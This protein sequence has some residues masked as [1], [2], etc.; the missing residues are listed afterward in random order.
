MQ[1]Q[2]RDLQQEQNRDRVL[3][4]LATPLI[5]LA[6]VIWG[7]S[8]VVMKS[9]VDV[10]PTFWL[11]AIRF[12]ASA[13]VLALVFWKRWK[14]ADKQ[15]FIGG[16][17]M[18][19]FLFLAYSF[20]TFGLEGT[21]PGKN[22]FLTAVY[23]VIVPFLYWAVAR[24]RPDRYNIAAAVLCIAGIGLVSVTGDNAA[25]VSMGDGLTLV[26]GFFFAAHIVAVSRFSQGRDI[27]LLTAIQFASFA[28]F[29]WLGVLATRPALPVEAAVPEHRPEVH[30]PRHGGGAAVPGGPLRR[31]VLRAVRRRAPHASD[32]AG[33]CPH[34]RG[35]HLFGDQVLLPPP[36]AEGSGPRG[37][38]RLRPGGG[39]PPG[40]PGS[41]SEKRAD[42][43]LTNV[44]FLRIMQYNKAIKKPMTERS[45]RC[46]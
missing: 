24:Q 46:G 5:I 15:Y 4:R 29:S 31:A 22:A 36:G 21:T 18:G 32:G 10:L 28:L 3:T 9:S 16:G 33:I 27:F 44:R 42:R 26:G 1:E 17:I 35:G 30:R 23:C 14:L 34:L 8:F 12:T 38:T 40:R 45:S 43:G 2:N 41:R 7:S 39:D 37:I 19:F 25:A 20:Q 11:L 6:T 13:I